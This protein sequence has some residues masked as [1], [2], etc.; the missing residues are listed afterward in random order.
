[1]AERVCIKYKSIIR[2]E[3]EYARYLEAREEYEEFLDPEYDPYE[4]VCV[5][6]GSVNDLPPF[7][8]MMYRLKRTDTPLTSLIARQGVKATWGW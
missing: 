2:D 5:E 7:E 1:M 3:E 8:R 6:W 4:S